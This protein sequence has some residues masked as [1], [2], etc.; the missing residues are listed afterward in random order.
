MELI[1]VNDFKCRE[2]QIPIWEAIS[3]KGYRKVLAVL[4]RRSGKDICAWNLCIHQALAKTCS[5]LYALPTYGQGRRVIWDCITTD[6]KQLLDYIPKR[7]IKNVNNSDM[8]ISFV[9][10]SQIQVIGADSYNTS[11]VGRNPYA[12]VF[13]EWSRCDPKAY[14]FARPILAN[15]GGWCLMITTPF[16]ANHCKQLFTYANTLKDWFVYLRK[17]SEI[18]HIPQDILDLEQAQMSEELYAQEYECSFDRGIDGS[19]YG[20]LISR[21]RDNNQLTHV[22]WDPSLLT[23]TAWDIG[24]SD[25]CVVVFF[26]VAY[27]GG[28]I[29]IIDCYS[30]SG[31]GLDHYVKMLQDKPYI[32]AEHFGPHDLRVREFGDSGISRFEKAGQLGLDFE[33]LPQASVVDGIENVMTHFPRFVIDNV[34]CRRL[35]EALEFYHRE[36][37]DEKQCY[38]PKPVHDFSSNFADAIRYMC[39]AIPRTKKGLTSE[40]FDR[41]KAE[42]LYGNKQ[43][44]PPEFMNTPYDRFRNY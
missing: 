11:I 38:S 19:I 37:S 7:F 13:S 18:K 42:A 40:E 27:D 32:Y 5:I 1:D 31:M 28:S 21:I 36:W 41:K 39:Q 20:K 6:G 2:Y 14:D 29:R 3:K 15:N 30:R 9:N 35:I 8:K 26:Q 4:P 43:T 12:I 16:G 33:V 10:N 44:L 23:Y 17:T 22:P 24:I 34:K 25:L